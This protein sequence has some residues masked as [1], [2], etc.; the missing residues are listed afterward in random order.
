MRKFQTLKLYLSFTKQKFAGLKTGGLVGL[1]ASWEFF[2]VLGGRTKRFDFF[3]CILAPALKSCIKWRLKIHDFPFLK[4]N[5]NFSRNYL[6]SPSKPLLHSTQSPTHG[7]TNVILLFFHRWRSY[8]CPLQRWGRPNWYLHSNWLTF[9]TSPCQKWI[10]C[11]WLPQ[12]YSMWVWNQ[13]IDFL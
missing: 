8:R 1:W 2:N 12:T 10:Q 3:I 11:I 6:G 5:R 9:T 13:I 7:K 4:L